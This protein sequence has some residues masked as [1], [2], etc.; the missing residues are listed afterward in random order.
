LKKI[1]I[2]TSGGDAP[3]MNAAIRSVV[4]SSLA[5]S[6][7][8]VGFIQGYQGM[9]DNDFL[10]LDSR[11]VGN[12]I[13]RGGTII[14]SGRCMEFLKESGRKTAYE[15]FKKHGLDA[16]VVIGGDGSMAGA[17]LLSQ[18]FGVPCV[19]I[20]GTIDNDIFGTDSTIGFDTACNTALDAIDRIRDTA[21]S[22]DRIFIVEV[23]GRDSGFLAIA[24]GVA[25]GAEQVFIP[26]NP[27]KIDDVVS[28]IK[29]GM[30]KG[31][32]SHILIAAEGKKPGRAYDLAESIRKKAGWEAKVC[33]LGHIQR[34]GAPTAHDRVLAG[35]MGSKAV[36]ALVN[37]QTGIMV[38]LQGTEIRAVSIDQIVKQKKTVSMEFIKLAFDLS[39]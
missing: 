2:I 14:K 8:V 27:V 6:I 33:V 22:H 28:H 19:G 10:P 3:G 37:N 36:T 20:P 29:N 21:T 34:G 12:I 1:G 31:K 25:G 17:Q 32:K 23:M 7:E 13:Q 9:I 16:L 30:S 18:E 5:N 4:R 39:H 24:V 35:R 15:N 38:G 26:E 11:A